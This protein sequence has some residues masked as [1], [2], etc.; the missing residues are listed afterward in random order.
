MD[1]YVSASAIEEVI[2]LLKYPETPQDDDISIEDLL[3]A[4][5]R[6]R[7][8]AP[9]TSAPR[10]GGSQLGGEMTDDTLE[11]N[12]RQLLTP[13]PSEDSALRVP[14]GYRQQGEWARQDVNPNPRDTSLIILGKRN[15]EQKDLN[16]FAIQ[17]Y[18]V[19]LGSELLVDYLQAFS[20]E[21]ASISAL[22]DR[23]PR[24]H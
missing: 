3:K 11:S 16:N 9:V 1:G 21:I 23:I 18:A 24:I 13:G 12:Q 4:R 14:E 10:A 19:R 2:E 20:T 15:R 22:V 17:S 7:Q 8:T 6:S 5:Q